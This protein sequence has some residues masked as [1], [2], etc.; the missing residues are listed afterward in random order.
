LSDYTNSAKRVLKLM[1]DMARQNPRLATVDVWASVL[2]ID[3]AG[4]N[5]DPHKIQ[6][7]LNAVR[8]E[9]DLIEQQMSETKFSKD[10][11][12]PYLDRVRKTVS[13]T[14]ISAS[15]ENYA[16][17]LSPDTLLALRYCSEELVSEPEISFDEL[18]ELLEKV[19]ALRLEIDSAPLS[20]PVRDFLLRQISIIERCIQ[21]YP[22]R[23]A[24]SFR[25]A[26]HEGATV[27]A[28][29]DIEPATNEEKAEAAKVAWLWTGLGK[30]A[31]T[32]VAT[33]KLA[34]AFMHLVEKGHA[35]GNVIGPLLRQITGS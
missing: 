4:A 35:A 30:A 16:N 20:R 31:K 18:T 33:D 17:N 25:Q 15:W 1:E 26:F 11:Y 10:L 32:V 22:I 3:A 28:S 8:E 19:N 24:Q 23:G 21:D 27:T 34:T 2:G 29:N 7:R 9:V 5:N 12:V 14:N 13:V 6:L